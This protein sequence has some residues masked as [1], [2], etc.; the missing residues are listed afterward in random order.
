MLAGIFVAHLRCQNH[1]TRLGKVI[2]NYGGE[3]A[4]DAKT[5]RAGRFSFQ[6][7][8]NEQCGVQFPCIRVF[9]SD[10]RAPTHSHSKFKTGIRPT[11]AE[12]P[13]SATKS[14]RATSDCKD[15]TLRQPRP[16][17]HRALRPNVCWCPP[18][19]PGSSC[20]PY[21]SSMPGLALVPHRSG[22]LRKSSASAA[23]AK[24]EPSVGLGSARA[25][26]NR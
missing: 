16:P 21:V 9:S 6:S 20:A 8:L 14:A 17:P 10:Q 11:R 12:P 24:P 19:L 4:A 25:I 5:I 3:R 2:A 26:P 13:A 7:M 15:R 23:R 1:S 18:R 22:P